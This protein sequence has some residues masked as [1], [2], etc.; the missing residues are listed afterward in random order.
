MKFVWFCDSFFIVN[1]IAETVLFDGTEVVTNQLM[2]LTTSLDS[3]WDSP[4][5]VRDKQVVTVGNFGEKWAA[6]KS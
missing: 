4:S 5:N 1:K 6:L 2:H 3:W